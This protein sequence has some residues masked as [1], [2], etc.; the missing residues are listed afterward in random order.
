MGSPQNLIRPARAL[1][2][3]GSDSGGGAGI[4]ADLKTFMALGVH[5]MSAI[6][7][8]TAQNTL[9]VSASHEVPADFVREQIAQVAT[10]I[11]IDAAKTGMLSSAEIVAAV[12]DAVVEFEI[13]KLVV[14]PVFISK[15]RDRLLSDDALSA[16]VNKLMPLASIVTPNLFEAGVILDRELTS[17]A[18]MKDAAISLFEM[19]P[20][21]VLVKGGHLAGPAIDVLYDGETTME[22]AAERIEG[23]N[24]H[25][26]GCTL[27]A[28]ITAGLAKGKE[29]PQ[30]VAEAKEFVTGAIRNGL[31]IGQGFGPTNPGWKLH[32][33]SRS[34]PAA[35]TDREKK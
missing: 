9:G 17:V 19:G 28:A 15:N 24:T 26:T 20:K 22:L 2:I 13:T 30:A 11:G 16:L 33:F 29:V 18:D 21:N 6:T 32:F 23:K 35:G 14:D 8:L 25:G 27:A 34:V 5:G 4:Q 1:T 31:A 10:D 7:A 3:A 12:A